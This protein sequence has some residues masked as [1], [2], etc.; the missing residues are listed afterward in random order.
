M[1]RSQT[2][3]SRIGTLGLGG[4]GDVVILGGVGMVASGMS[5]AGCGVRQA[6]RTLGRGIWVP[7]GCGSPGGAVAVV[8]IEGRVGSIVGMENAVAG[9][10]VS[11]RGGWRLTY[12]HTHWVNICCWYERNGKVWVVGKDL[13]LFAGWG[14]LWCWVRSWAGC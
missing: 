14:C 6:V 8:L 12:L 3:Q 10:L 11:K 4:R 7:T 2:M 9:R 13:L 1:D 5:G